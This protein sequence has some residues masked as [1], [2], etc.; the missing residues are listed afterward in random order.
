MSKKFKITLVIVCIWLIGG[1]IASFF[2]KKGKEEF[3]PVWKQP[4]KEQT[5]TEAG[6][7]Q[8]TDN[9][10]KSDNNQVSVE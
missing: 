5:Q 2:V 1:I 7:Q 4:L 3:V 9:S 6:N 8:E 10:E